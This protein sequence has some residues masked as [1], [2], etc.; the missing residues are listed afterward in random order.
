MIT[1]SG[2]SSASS[3]NFDGHFVIRLSCS[4]TSVPS[5]ELAG[6]D[7][8]AALAEGVGDRARVATGTLVAGLVAIGD[9]EAELGLA[10]VLTESS[11]TIAV[12]LVAVARPGR[13]QV[14]RRFASVEALNDV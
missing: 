7:H 10:R 9:L 11:S 5:V 12:D 6:D 13:E 8:L 14:A 3:A 2:F 1:W 4:P